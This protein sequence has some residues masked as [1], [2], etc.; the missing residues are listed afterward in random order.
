MVNLQIS[1]REN[2]ALLLVTD[3]G[4]SLLYSIIVAGADQYT[5][6]VQA[7]IHF[8]KLPQQPPNWPPLLSPLFS[9]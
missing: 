2:K 8:L 5:I 9:T 1:E 7:I 3:F 6:L 4:G